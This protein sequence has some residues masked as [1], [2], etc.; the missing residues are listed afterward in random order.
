MR[1]ALHALK[2][3]VTGKLRVSTMRAL[4][5]YGK[6]RQCRRQQK[7]HFWTWLFFAVERR[8]RSRAEM[9]VGRRVAR[10]L[11]RSYWKQ[12]FARFFAHRA[13]C[14]CVRGCVGVCEGVYACC[15]SIGSVRKTQRKDQSIGL[16]PTISGA[17]AR[18]GDGLVLVMDF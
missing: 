6:T 2:T 1:T 17:C 9:S 10:E 18:G 4:I 13:R 11:T 15:F 7:H 5:I 16:F 14:V 12:W 8:W 3:G